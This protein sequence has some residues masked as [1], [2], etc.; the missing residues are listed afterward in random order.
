VSVVSPSLVVD[1]S[2]VDR[3]PG[4]DHCVLRVDGLE[5]S[6]HKGLPPR[7]RRVE[8]LRGA[9]LMV[10]SG[11]LVGLVG[12]NGS[13]KSTLMQIVV[14]LLDR[15]GGSVDQLARLGYCPIDYRIPYR[16]IR[17]ELKA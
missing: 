7:R 10:C 3:C 4:P 15:D 9:N 5:K 8:V 11:E 13:G 16:S 12:E 6:F 1:G 14:G 17:E 2:D